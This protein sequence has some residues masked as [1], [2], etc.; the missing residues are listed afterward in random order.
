VLANRGGSS[1]N[2]STGSIY[3]IC[4]DDGSSHF[5]DHHNVCVGFGLKNFLGHA[6]I[7]ESNLIVRPDLIG[8]ESAGG[9]TS[10]LYQVPMWQTSGVLPIT[11]KPI[12]LRESYRNN[13]CL[14][15]TTTDPYQANCNW[16]PNDLNETFGAKNAYLLSHFIPKLIILPR[17][18]RDKHRE[19]SKHRCVFRR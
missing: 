3:C 6:Q 19:S 2:G 9:A 10:C 15:A 14:L 17:Q 1:G 7:F 11:G 8:A 4:H 13:T 12:P 5:H 18:A 16:K